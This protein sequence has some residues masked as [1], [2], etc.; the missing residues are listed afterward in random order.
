MVADF[1]DSAGSA[2]LLAVLA[3]AALY[4]RRLLLQR[5]G[6]SLDCA[7]RVGKHRPGHGWHFGVVRYTP[8]HLEWFRTFSAAPQPKYTFVRP[9]F[10]VIGRRYPRNFEQHSMPRD[11]VVLHCTARTVDGRHV[12]LELAVGEAALTGVL[13]WLESSPPGLHHHQHQPPDVRR[14][15]G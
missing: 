11:A 8:Y 1:L 13:A 6:A 15:C 9:S 2:L 5:G 14:S 7:L 3:V 4:V 12:E 10:D